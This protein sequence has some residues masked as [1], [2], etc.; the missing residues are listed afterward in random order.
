MPTAF[1]PG[2]WKDRAWKRLT[3]TIERKGD[4][5]SV[6]SFVEEQ[7]HNDLMHIDKLGLLVDWCHKKKLSVVFSGKTIGVY[8]PDLRQISVSL[9]ASPERQV[10]F[11][12]HEIGHHMIGMDPA[13]ERFGIGYPQGN[14]PEITKTFAHR[15]ACL[16]EE[17]EAWHR[18]WRISKRL[19]LDLNRAKFDE[20]RLECLRSYL[21]WTVKK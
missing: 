18:G 13:H 5:P 3:R 7:W 17:F 15:I 14:V 10:Y 1:N 2:V 21:N 12:L 6:R 9:R 19:K 4:P 16:E 8:D 20:V 11:L